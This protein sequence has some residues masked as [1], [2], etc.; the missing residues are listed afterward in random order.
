MRTNSH[1][2]T[3]RTKK[4]F[5]SPLLGRKYEAD[6]SNGYRFGMNTQE[7]DDELYGKG[8][9]TNATFWE[10]DTRLG[11]RWNIDPVIKV[12]ESSYTCFTNN[13]ILF[14]DPLGDDVSY[15]NFRDRFNT[16]MGRI[17]SKSFRANY[18]AWK[19]SPLDYHIQQVDNSPR[20]KDAT[21]G[22]LRIPSRRVNV[23]YALGKPVNIS[24]NL[25]LTGQKEMHIEGSIDLDAGQ[26]STTVT[27]RRP[28]PNTPITLHPLTHPTNFNLNDQ[29]GNNITNTTLEA[30]DSDNPNKMH[31]NVPGLPPVTR[32]PAG[33]N[34]VAVM[35]PVNATRINAIISTR[36]PW[37]YIISPNPT[38]FPGVSNPSGKS[39]DAY[40]IDYFKVTGFR[41]NI[42]IN[43]V[44]KR[45]WY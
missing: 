21:P 32:L 8:N 7:K 10:Y 44:Y 11:R 33:T 38:V 4:S 34:T 5:G 29:N 24:F 23:N 25:D 35:T 30:V 3:Q 17:F 42:N 41:I 37:P 40:K 36:K 45:Y 16:L 14:D 13:P 43:F 15:G 19:A 27:L 26:N 1:H 6:T 22:N 9:A 39:G 12:W 18:K 20:L 28:V 2:I 31:Q